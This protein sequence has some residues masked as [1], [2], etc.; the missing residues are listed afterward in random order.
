MYVADV[1]SRDAVNENDPVPIVNELTD[2]VIDVPIKVASEFK[3][4]G[5]NTAI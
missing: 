1:E 4:L 3:L 5:A 2:P